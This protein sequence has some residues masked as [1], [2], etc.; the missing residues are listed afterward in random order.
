MNV[1]MTGATGLIGSTLTQRLLDHGHKVTA[2]TRD[3]SA[4]EKKLGPQVSYITSLAQL[5]NL[6]DFNACINLAG[7]PIA[8]KRWSEN[9]KRRIE[10]SRWNTTQS[11]VDL[12]QRSNYPPSV[13]ISGSAVG[14]YGKQGNSPITENI[15]PFHQDFSHRLCANWEDIA[16]G[17][18]SAKTRVCLLRTGIVLSHSGGALSKLLL[19]FKLG[20]GG[21]IGNGRHHMSWIHIDDM[22]EGIL[23]LL[24][25][26][27]C[28]GA[29]N[30]TAPSPVTN[31]EFTLTLGKVLRR[32]TLLPTPPLLLKILF[33]EMSELLIQGQNVVPDKLQK[34]G[35]KFKYVTL[36]KALNSLHL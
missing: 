6:D 23:F 24:Q 21:P 7:E 10:S 11:L 9:Q 31:R 36:E 15:E 26:D 35:F 3:P 32:P 16:L 22:V 13:L 28:Q 5:R 20:L 12:I 8:D 25:Q 2:L 34:S 29:F 19:P 14:Y 4:A 27:N 18:D 17:A 30:L 1:L 33:G